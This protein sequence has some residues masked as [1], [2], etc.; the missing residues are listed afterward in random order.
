MPRTDDSFDV[1]VRPHLPVMQRYAARLA[2]PS[3][4]EE[5]VQEALLRAWRR[6]ST[7]DHARGTASAWLLAIVRDRARRRGRMQAASL[8]SRTTPASPDPAAA[9]GARPCGADD[10]TVLKTSNGPAMGTDYVIVRLGLVGASPCHLD[11]FPVVHLLDH[12]RVLDVP[13]RHATDTDD[14]YGEEKAVLVTSSAPATFR[15]SRSTTSC[16]A[17]DSDATRVELPGISASFTIPGFGHTFCEPGDSTAPTISVGPIQPLRQKAAHVTSPYNEVKATGSL[18]HSARAG[19]PL[20]FTITLT[21]EQDLPLGPCPDYTIF[22]DAGQRRYALNCAAVP[23]RDAVG[24]PYL[25]AGVPVT[26]AMRLEAGVARDTKLGW[27][28]VTPSGDVGVGS[29][30]TVVGR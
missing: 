21:A 15:M 16:P 22:T 10:L 20:D 29:I 25:P 6:W 12:G 8:P 1:W 28:L 27:R 4:A 18:P 2:G 9:A 11:G 17:N 7:Y 19:Q 5:V 13:V 3:E 23:H 14:F 24:R 26:F 30:V